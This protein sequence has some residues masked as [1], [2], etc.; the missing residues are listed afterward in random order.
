MFVVAPSAGA[1]QAP[2]HQPKSTAKALGQVRYIKRGLTV[3]PPHKQPRRGT[4]KMRL[5][6]GYFLQTKAAQLASVRFNDGTLLH[7]NQRT[8]V[9]LR[10]PHL[11]YVKRGEVDQVTTPG[12]DHRVQTSTAL[13][14]AIGTELDV[15][16]VGKNTIVTVVEG[17]G[18]VSNKLGSVIVKTGQQTVVA[19]NQPPQPP[20]PANAQATV[21][22]TQP[23]P[24]P[25]QSIAQNIALDFNGG[26]IVGYSS[27]QPAPAARVAGRSSPRIS[28]SPW[29]VHYINDGLL[30]RGWESATGHASNQYVKLGFISDNVA[31]VTGVVID[32]AATG[33]HSASNDLKDFEIK[34]STSGTDDGSFTV[35]FRGV[36]RQKNSL[37]RFDF[38]SPVPARYVELYALD[39]YGGRAIAVSE[40]EISATGEPVGGP[41]P[42]PVSTPAATPTATTVCG[43]GSADPAQTG[44]C[45]QLIVTL[46]SPAQPKVGVGTTVQLVAHTV[47]DLSGST[48]RIV[49]ANEK[50]DRHA[51][52]PGNN[53]C[54]WEVA[55]TAPVTRTYT[56]WIESAG[57]QKA[58]PISAAV[59]ETWD[60]WKVVDLQPP[61]Q[62]VT[63]GQQATVTA[64][65][66]Y[67]LAQGYTIRLTEDTGSTFSC[68]TGKTCTWNLTENN[69][70]TRS[71]RAGVYDSSGNRVD[72]SSDLSAQVTWQAKP[73]AWSGTVNLTVDQT[74]IPAG[75]SVTLTATASADVSGT[76]F[77]IV[78]QADTGN[79]KSC[80]SGTVCAW[81]VR[82]TTPTSHTFT[83]FVRDPAGG[84]AATGP[85]T[86]T[87]VWKA[88]TIT[89]SVDQSVVP[90]GTSVNLT[91]MTNFDVHGT[92]LV[93][94]IVADTGNQGTC[95]DGS[96]CVWTVNSNAPATHSFVAYVADSTGL[97]YAQSSSQ[98]VTW[99]AT[100]SI[101]LSAD[102]EYAA[103]GST[104]HLTATVNQDWT[105]SGYVL[106]LHRD[107]S[108]GYVVDT[109]TVPDFMW[110][111]HFYLT[112]DDGEP[113]GN[114]RTYVITLEASGVP[115]AAVS[116]S[117]T[118]TWTS[119][120]QRMQVPQLT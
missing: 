25:A 34:V 86:V 79:T 8:D 92:G 93:I 47:D 65:I 30:D 114:P 13:A 35:V 118:I 115:P 75:V 42:T 2:A 14:A 5:Y 95:T 111:C 112:Y 28:A 55:E 119:L 87:V 80:D 81:S 103:I 72:L 110:G 58:G 24:P 4:V 117:V 29:D 63:V 64:T 44:G 99:Q 105:G 10:T 69:P 82:S 7:I 66:N 67:D 107:N 37:Q 98:T 120:L 39:N 51:C 104:V 78:I 40:L 83:V 16:I 108:S 116:N 89:L 45:K 84:N 94:Q 32:P 68:A 54:T 56:A 102:T 59:T 43:T 9:V 33:G 22:W 100:W 88:W 61:K 26:H 41:T 62:T 106:K 101:M 113:A 97:T 46:Q 49:I 76:G 18:R 36:T 90:V 17:A 11:T 71:V 15:R 6:K 20:S 38:P 52:D 12:T 48:N 85:N 23:I 96:S 91:A 70:A 60:S 74:S 1:S 19:P 109:C 3:Q 77:T 31:L 73:P 27:Q 53:S 50:G 57:G 21:S